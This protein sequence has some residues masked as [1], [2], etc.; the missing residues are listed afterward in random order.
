MNKVM[1]IFLVLAGLSGCAT[2]HDG[3]G[4]EHN[5]GGESSATLEHQH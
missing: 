5:M 2:L 4:W 1:L 3:S